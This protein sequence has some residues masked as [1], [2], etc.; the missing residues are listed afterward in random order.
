MAR[1]PARRRPGAERAATSAPYRGGRPSTAARVT[2]LLALVVTSAVSVTSYRAARSAEHTAPGGSSRTDTATGEQRLEGPLWSV[3]PRRVPSE[4]F[5]LTLN[6]DTGGMPGFRTGAVRLWDSETRWGLIEKRPRHYDWS[7]LDRMVDSAGRRGLPVLFT[8]GGTPRWAAPDGRRSAYKDS[9]SS[10]P[11]DL[12]D[13]DRFVG[14]VAER[15]RDRIEAYEL[16]DYPSHRLHWAGSVTT[17]AEMVERASG[18]IRRADPGAVLACPSFGR[19]WTEQG[20][21]RLREFARTG[22]Y[23]HCHAAALKLPPRRATR[24]P[25]ESIELARKVQA[26]LY[27]EGVGDIPVWNTGT[28]RDVAV[29]DPLDARRARDYAVRFYLSGVYSRHYGVRRTYF[30]SWGSTG[31]PLVVQPVGGRPT[32]AGV[33]MG[34]LMDWLDGAG[35]TAC[36]EGARMGLAEGAYV[37]RFVRGDDRLLVAWTTRG[38]AG[39]TLAEGAYRL[40]RMDGGTAHVR[41]GDRVGFGEEPVLVEHHRR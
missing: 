34:R 15:Y 14:K 1:A 27:E 33:R 9:R 26:L 20:R 12:K 21:D 5:G 39:I 2:L 7:G 19:L 40:R 17:L 31:V 29:T 18:I 4:F 35:V 30:Y 24:P 11:D 3:S 6:T 25:E 16:W 38:R 22:A 41:E 13:W 32:E 23:D 36:G 8:F 28:D 10:P 37:C